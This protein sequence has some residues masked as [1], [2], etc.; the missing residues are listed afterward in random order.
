[1]ALFVFL[2]GPAWARIIPA[3]LVSGPALRHRLGLFS[4][5]GH[6]R[7]LKLPLLLLPKLPLNGINRGLR[8]GFP[9]Q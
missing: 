4:T 1:M 7:V 9:V 3:H 8:Y 5:A 2:A 6:A